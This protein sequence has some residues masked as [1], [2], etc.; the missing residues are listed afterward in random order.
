M[1]LNQYLASVLPI[2][3][4]QAD[5]IIQKS[6]VEVN[7]DIAV[8]GQKLSDGDK[9]RVY[10]KNKWESLEDFEDLDG[11]SQGSKKNKV[12]LM[13]K[14][15]FCMCTKFDP[16][17]RKTIYDML[18]GI[19]NKY[20]YAGRLDYMSEGLVVLS[21]DG[22]LIESLTH[23]KFGCQKGYLVGLKKML[24]N[25]FIMA[26]KSGMQIQEKDQN[27]ILKSVKITSL[28]LGKLEEYGYLKLD[29]KTFWYR[30]DLYEGRNQQIRKM[31]EL[32]D[33]QLTRLIRIQH[34]R[35]YLDQ[36]IKDK[37]YITVEQS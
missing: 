6:L 14:P 7:G 21:T 9:L 16:Q 17:G 25:D 26:A 11:G 22:N 31:I 3:R 23:P 29:E 15:I 33:N 36:E 37:R 18:P 10:R 12:L 5:E 20:K 2:S 35:Y 4:R 8:L 32:T 27:Y 30:F 1:R 28:S 19:Y 24:E 34:D 13:Y